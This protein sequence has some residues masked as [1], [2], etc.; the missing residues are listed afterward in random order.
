MS[1]RSKESDNEMEREASP[2][3]DLVFDSVVV[4]EGDAESEFDCVA[5][6]RFFEIVN[7]SSLENVC[8]GVPWVRDDESVVDRSGVLDN[9]GLNVLVSIGVSELDFE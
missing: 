4:G 9:V 1:E 8:D 2:V 6:D 5:V 7:V 3:A